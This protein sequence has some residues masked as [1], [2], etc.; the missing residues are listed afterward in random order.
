MSDMKANVRPP[1]AALNREIVDDRDDQLSIHTH[2]IRLTQAHLPYQPVA[3]KR[4][5]SA[6]HFAVFADRIVLDGVLTN[7]GRN[8]ELNA[9]EIVI[10]KPVT[11]D[12]AGAYAD[13]DFEP[14][15]S[16]V[17]KD[18]RD[19][20]AGTDGAD[21]GNGGSIVINARRVSNKTADAHALSA[22]ELAAIGTRVFAEHPPKIDNTGKLERFEFS[23]IKVF[24]AETVIYLGDGRV[25]GF[26]RLVLESAQLDRS[27]EF[28]STPLRIASCV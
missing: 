6:K 15:K 13:K 3:G 25:E 7:P 28:V 14:G 1:A 21:G 4:L 23:R 2:E 17:Q 24:G 27:A 10:E 18:A 5:P 12:V 8:I 11:L 20:A 22:T 26:A 16:A 19:G 9:R